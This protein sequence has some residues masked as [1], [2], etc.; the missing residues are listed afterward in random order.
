MLPAMSAEKAYYALIALLA[1]AS[2]LLSPFFFVRRRRA[3]PPPSAGR[4]RKVWLANLLALL[5]FLLWHAF[6]R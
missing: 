6:F 4:W 3:L 2:L 5:L 1:A